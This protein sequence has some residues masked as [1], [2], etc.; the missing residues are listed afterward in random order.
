M[1]IPEDKPSVARTFFEKAGESAKVKRNK[2]SERHPSK[3]D[4]VEISTDARERQFSK[5]KDLVEK[6]PDIR[7]DKVAAVKTA[8]DNETYEV[9]GKEIAKKMVKESIDELV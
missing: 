5:I 9:K 7:E 2:E 1:K 4:K 3:V 8:I 6:A